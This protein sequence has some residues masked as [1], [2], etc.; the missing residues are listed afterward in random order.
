MK[1]T[2]TK[3]IIIAM[4]TKTRRTIKIILPRFES[5][6]DGLTSFPSTIEYGV[7]VQY[8]LSEVTPYTIAV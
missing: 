2:K 1:Y 5:G 7:Y 8:S 3:A 4:I 6:L